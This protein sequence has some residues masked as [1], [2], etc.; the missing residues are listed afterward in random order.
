MVLEG[1]A[2]VPFLREDELRWM[3]INLVD[4]TFME[5][6]GWIVKLKSKSINDLRKNLHIEKPETPRGSSAQG[7]SRL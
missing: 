7:S 6:V 4:G 5:S 2:L 3:T 1:D